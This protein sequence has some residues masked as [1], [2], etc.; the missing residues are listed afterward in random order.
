MK[1]KLKRLIATL[2]DEEITE[3]IEDIFECAKLY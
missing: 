2:S 1:D 3:Q